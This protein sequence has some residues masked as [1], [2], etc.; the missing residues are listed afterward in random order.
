MMISEVPDIE[1]TNIESR[2]SSEAIK[3]LPDEV[4]QRIILL[5]RTEHLKISHEDDH[6]QSHPDD[7]IEDQLQ[8]TIKPKDRLHESFED[9][10]CAQNWVTMCCGLTIDGQKQLLRSKL[11]RNVL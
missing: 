4:E 8:E 2:E 10:G 3:Q 5:D 1:I 6:F 11:G 9:V 7:E